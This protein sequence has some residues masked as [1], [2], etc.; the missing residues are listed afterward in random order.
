MT[1]GCLR[2]ITSHHTVI[3]TPRTPH[4]WAWGE[5]TQ[6]PLGLALSHVEE[7]KCSITQCYSPHPHTHYSSL[8]LAADWWLVTQMYVHDTCCQ[9]LTNTSQSHTLSMLVFIHCLLPLW[10]RLKLTVRLCTVS[11]CLTHVSGILTQLTGFKSCLSVWGEVYLK[12]CM[13]LLIWNVTDGDTRAFL[14][15]LKTKGVLMNSW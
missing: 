12:R 3:H 11:D 6:P 8:T 1:A 2:V 14:K 10:S 13:T 7:A 5:A 15:T 9:P 4:D